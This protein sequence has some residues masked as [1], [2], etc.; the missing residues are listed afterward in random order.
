MTTSVIKVKKLK[1]VDW[2]GQKQIEL[3]GQGI[4]PDTTV[5]EVMAAMVRLMELPGNTPYS[6]FYKNQKLNRSETIEEI[7]IE[8]EDEVVVAPE[9][10]AG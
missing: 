1:G 10:T 7:G 2:S 8:N 5:S 4:P 3:N 9:V 6:L